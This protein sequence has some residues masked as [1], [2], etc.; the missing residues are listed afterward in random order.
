MSPKISTKFYN[1]CIESLK[2]AFKEL[3]NYDQADVFYDIYRAACI[4]EFEIILEQSGKLLRKVLKD[5]YSSPKKVYEL[6]FKDI[7][8]A[9]NQ[10]GLMTDEAA[11]RWL[12]YRDNRNITSHDYGEGFASQTLELLPDFVEDALTLK[13]VIETKL[14]QND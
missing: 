11:E 14:Q 1:K 2:L 5:Y 9:A 8:R 3:E 12:E 7:F 10:F 4:K 13:T 6:N